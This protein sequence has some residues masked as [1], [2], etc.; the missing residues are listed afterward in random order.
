V[1]LIHGRP[2]LEHADAQKFTARERLALM[3][4]ICDAVEHAHQRGVIH[5]RSEAEQHPCG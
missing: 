4:K 2:L 5:P 1:E 3:A